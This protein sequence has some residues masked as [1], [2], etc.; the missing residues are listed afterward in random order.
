MFKRLVLVVLVSAAGLA[1]AGCSK[2]YHIQIQS[3]TCWEG[4]VDGDEYFTDCGD[5][6]YKVI[7]TLTCVELTKTTSNGYLRMRVDGGPWAQTT[8]PYGRVQ[9]CK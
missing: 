3:D 4:D 8:D 7:G 9:I 6:N 2:T 5:S 1:F